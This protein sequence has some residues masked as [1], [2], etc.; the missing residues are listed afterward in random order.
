MESP[1][2]FDTLQVRTPGRAVE[3]VT[4]ALDAGI[5]LRLVDPTASGSAFDERTS[6]HR[7][8]G[9]AA[10]GRSPPRTSPTAPRGSRAAPAARPFDLPRSP[11]FQ[12]HRSETEMMRYLRRLAD[13]DLALDRTMIPLGSCTMK[14]NAA[15]EMIPITWPELQRLHPF[16][17]VEQAAGYLRAH[18]SSSKRPLPHHRVR[19]RVPAAQRRFPGRTGR[20]ARH[21]PLPPRPRGDQ[22][23]NVCL[24]PDSA[25]GTN[26]A[27]AVMAGMEV[28]VVATDDAGNIDLDRPAERR[29]PNTQR[30]WPP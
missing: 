28:V 21:R 15:I 18:R 7:R 23:R 10:F 14:L 8:A 17:P 20:S 11:D 2:Y 26:A 4:A 16:A 5:N 29:P 19:R 1:T 9:A 22:A 3:V 6:E 27:S 13:A 12:A 24:I 25:H 30:S